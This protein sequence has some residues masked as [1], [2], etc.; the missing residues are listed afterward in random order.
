[1]IPNIFISSTIK[2]L[3]YL[4]D[5]IRDLIIELGFNPIMSEYGGVGYLPS[6][7]AENSCYLA[8]KDCQ[9]AIIIVGKRYGSIS[10]NGF[11]I[12]HNEFKT[13]RNQKIPV[14]F[15]INEETLSFQSVFNSNSNKT[16][17]ELPGMDN[18]SKVFS[19]IKEF[20]E[21]DINN[22]IV[23]YSTMQSAKANLKLQLA[24]LF[25]DL[26]RKEFDSE[27]NNLK[28]ILSQITTLKHILLKNDEDFASKFAY[29]FRALLEDENNYLKDICEEVYENLEKA[30][31]SILEFETLNEFLKNKNVDIILKTTE[32]IREELRFDK[33]DPFEKGIMK[34]C[35]SKL[36]Y[37]SAK[38]R[39]NIGGEPDYKIEPE[40]SDDKL[41]IFGFGK[42]KYIGNKNSMNLIEA[43]YNRIR[44]H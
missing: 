34:I 35:H 6:D 23:S 21:S 13:A 27:Q 32:I 16:D 3:H 24:H 14:I 10:N 22:G 36:P 20:A 8:M 2:D 26:L 43:M 18:P 9:L 31:T 12:T 40:P 1:M 38:S 17:L 39:A 4:R 28:D 7:S 44:K 5:A 25:G 19:F 29:S 15:L 41:I 37:E 42:N 33:F 11:S 30:V